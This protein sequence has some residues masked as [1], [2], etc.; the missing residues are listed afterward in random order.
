MMC[1]ATTSAHQY[2]K[3]NWWRLRS[4]E[5][6]IREKIMLVLALFPVSPTLAL[7]AYVGHQFGW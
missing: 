6:T 5:L 2:I 4:G 1:R 3:T 7:I